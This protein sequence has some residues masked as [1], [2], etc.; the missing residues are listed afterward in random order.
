MFLQLINVLSKDR[1]CS[2]RTMAEK[3]EKGRLNSGIYCK[4]LCCHQTCHFLEL[5]SVVSKMHGI[6]TYAVAPPLGQSAQIGNATA[7]NRWTTRWMNDQTTVGQIWV[8][9]FPPRFTVGTKV[10]PSPEYIRPDIHIQAEE[11]HLHRGGTIARCG[12]AQSF[13]D[14]TPKPHWIEKLTEKRF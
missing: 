1:K 6:Q 9:S 3:E 14:F 4:V 7:C 12:L 10:Q 5:Q 11:I 13:K 8:S 2:Q